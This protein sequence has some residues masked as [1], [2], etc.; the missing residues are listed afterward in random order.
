MSNAQAA[1]TR[2][3]L[4]PIVSFIIPVAVALL[5]TVKVQDLGWDVKPLTELPPIYA[6]IN[7]LTAVLLVTSV[8]SIKKGHKALHQRL[9]TLAL[10][11]SIL[12]LLLYVAYHSTAPAT[13]FGDINHDQMLDEAEL[14]AIGPMRWVYLFVLLSHI[15]L[16]II[17]LPIVLYT[18]HFA[19]NQEWNKHRRW[20]KWAF[21]LWLYVAVTGVL[22]YWMISPYYYEII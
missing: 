22:V 9:N 2:S 8:W 18:F 1:A 13:Y 15:G 12:F 11:C 16:S 21:P 17:I 6:T 4:I 3:R 5:F 10:G 14:A 20:A 19:W 7:A